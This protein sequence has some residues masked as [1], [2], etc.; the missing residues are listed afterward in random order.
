MI[1]PEEGKSKKAKGKRRRRGG[2]RRRSHQSLMMRES[3]PAVFSFAFC[4]FTFALFERDGP[5]RRERADDRLGGLDEGERVDADEDDEDGAD[6]ERRLQGGRERER[7]V[8]GR[9]LADVHRAYEAHVVVEA[10]DR[11]EGRPAGEPVVPVLPLGRPPLDD[12]AEEEPL[13]DEAA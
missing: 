3:V 13:A 6:D 10:D 1:A 9:A 12:A 5:A 2:G 4:L 8:V 11:V 7:A